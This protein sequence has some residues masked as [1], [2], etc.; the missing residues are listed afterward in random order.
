MQS[1]ACV[2]AFAAYFCGHAAAAEPPI[3]GGLERAGAEKFAGAVLVS[4]LGCAACHGTTQAE[5]AAKAG[6][7]LSAVGA[8]VNRGFFFRHPS[9]HQNQPIPR[10]E[11][12]SIDGAAVFDQDFISPAK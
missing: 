10:R 9:L 12:H 7:D 11:L 3:I 1:V 2:F 4:E 8:R 5:F 6:P